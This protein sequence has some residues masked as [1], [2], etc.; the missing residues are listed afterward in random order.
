[1]IMLN[2]SDPSRPAESRVVFYMRYA[3]LP[4]DMNVNITASY[5]NTSGQ[6]ENIPIIHWFIFQKCLNLPVS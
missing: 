4:A 6:L 1:M 3:Y 2:V 5:Q